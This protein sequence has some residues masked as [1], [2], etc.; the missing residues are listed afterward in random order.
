M[1]RKAKDLTAGAEGLDVKQFGALKKAVKQAQACESIRLDLESVQSTLDV[2]IAVA[3]RP[4]SEENQLLLH[5]L[6]THAFIVY[7]RASTSSNER[8]AIGIEGAYSPEQ[9]DSHRRVHNLRDKC[10]A[11]F[12]EN[13]GEWNSEK[14]LYLEKEETNSITFVHKRTHVDFWIVAVMQDLLKSAIPHV[15]EKRLTSVNKVDAEIRKLTDEQAAKFLSVSFDQAEFFG[16]DSAL[17]EHFWQT[18]SF[19]S[20]FRR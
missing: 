19:S 15:L 17:G 9:R 13:G 5:A 6:L 11:H 14:V 3:K 4:D 10:I 12:G 18:D 1:A 2:L 8:F 16:S 7:V 20:T